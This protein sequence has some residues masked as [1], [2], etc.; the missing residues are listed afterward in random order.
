M[1]KMMGAVLLVIST[2][3]FG[4]WKANFYAARNKEL[5]DLISALQLLETEISYSVTPLPDALHRIGSRLAGR[6]GVF[7]QNAGD[8]LLQGDGRSAGQIFSDQLERSRTMIHLREQ[9]LEILRTFGHT[10]GSSDRSDQLKHI[11]LANSR[12]MAEAQNARDEKER[13]GKMWRYLGALTGLAGV[14]I[15]Y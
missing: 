5:E 13:L 6:M 15:I 3:G 12:L 14:I 11:R 7:L 2:T 4:L 8:E 1:I 10:L 9:D